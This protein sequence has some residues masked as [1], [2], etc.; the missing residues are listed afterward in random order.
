MPSDVEFFQMSRCQGHRCL[1]AKVHRVGFGHRCLG[2][3]CTSG[4][5]SWCP[6]R[7][8]GRGIQDGR[9]V[10]HGH[11]IWL[12]DVKDKVQE[13]LID[14]LKPELISW[15]NYIDSK[16]CAIF[17]QI[18]LKTNR[19]AGGAAFRLRAGRSLQV[20]G[21]SST[22]GTSEQQSCLVDPWAV[23][24]R[25]ACTCR[26]HL[27]VWWR[28]SDCRTLNCQKKWTWSFTR[29]WARLLVA[30]AQQQYKKM[31]FSSIFLS[32]VLIQPM[33]SLFEAL[34]L[35]SEMPN[36][37]CRRQLS[38]A[39]DGLCQAGPALSWRQQRC[40]NQRRDSYSR[41]SSEEYWFVRM[42]VGMRVS[43]HLH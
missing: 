12:G 17:S 30:K 36:A 11:Q 15:S 25:S 28:N 43:P 7:L 24:G 41:D 6:A 9:F 26:I 20:C 13:Q 29:S 5:R 19:S 18:G 40:R 21:R 2:S 35:L 32:F 8:R 1:G 22:S 33:Y 3:P 39:S 38:K 27:G 34:W 16:I 10:G 4:S 14:L 37:F 23:S 31:G 42:T